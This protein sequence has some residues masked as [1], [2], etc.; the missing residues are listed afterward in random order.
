MHKIY[1][2]PLQIGGPFGFKPSLHYR[3]NFKTF[4]I[5]RSEVFENKASVAV[6]IIFFS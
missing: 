4:T 5:D 1:S 2:L 3:K 6:E